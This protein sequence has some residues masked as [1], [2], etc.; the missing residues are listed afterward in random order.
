[1]MRTKNMKLQEIGI[2]VEQT[3]GIV[4]ALKNK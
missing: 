3:M 1:M 2:E 4:F